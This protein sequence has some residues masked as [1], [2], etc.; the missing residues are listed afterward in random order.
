MAVI[1]TDGV[2]GDEATHTAS[3]ETEVIASGSF[4]NNKVQIMVNQTGAA[5]APAFTFG[6]PAA[7]KLATA[8]GTT[9]TAVIVGVD[10]D[11]AIDVST[12]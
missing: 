9:I 6:S 10:A 12:T 1:I 11:S 8:V 5:P 3:G 7:I 2:A 4:K